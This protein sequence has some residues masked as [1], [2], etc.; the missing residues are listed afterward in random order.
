MPSAAKAVLGGTNRRPGQT[1]GRRFAAGPPGSLSLAPGAA[2]HLSNLDQ[3]YY[4]YMGNQGITSISG[5]QYARNL[6][7]PELRSEGT[8]SSSRLKQ[9]HW[10]SHW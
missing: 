8:T 2:I 3:L 9:S 10:I 4:L 1:T 7:W 5:L 6:S